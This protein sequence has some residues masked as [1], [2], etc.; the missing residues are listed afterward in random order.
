MLHP[1]TVEDQASEFS[2]AFMP[3]L[4]FINVLVVVLLV[5]GWHIFG[6]ALDWLLQEA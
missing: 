5:G 1:V 2:L 4:V 3:F 6:L